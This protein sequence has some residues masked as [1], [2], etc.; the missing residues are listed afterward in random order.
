MSDEKTPWGVGTPWKNDVA[1]YTFLRGCLRLSWKRHPTKLKVIKDSRKQIPNPNPRGNKPT[2]FGFECPLCGGEF[3]LKDGQVDHIVPAGSLRCK[4]DIQG[5][6]ERLLWITEKDLRLVCKV[7]N[8]ALSLSEKMGI[9]Y[10]EAIREKLAIVWEKE[11]KGI[12]T[13]R[14]VLYDLG[15]EDAD[16]LKAKDIRK[17]YIEYLKQQEK[18]DA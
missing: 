7:C 18:N 12:A 1:F 16:K 17:A 9:T 4:E 13:Q 3:V 15:I 2:V 11:N 8:N 5:F 6:I 10:E 14:K